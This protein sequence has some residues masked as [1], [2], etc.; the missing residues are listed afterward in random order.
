[1]S[2]TTWT[3]PIPDPGVTS[4]RVRGLV[5]GLGFWTAIVLPFVYLPSLALGPMITVPPSLLATAVALNVLALFVGHRH[6]PGR[7]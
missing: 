7:E 4:R 3:P 5:A 1:M 6:D 2:G